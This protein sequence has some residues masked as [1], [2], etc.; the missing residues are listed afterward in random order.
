MT[1]YCPAGSMNCARFFKALD[2]LGISTC[3]INNQVVASFEQCP[4]PS[5][6]VTIDN[7]DYNLAL[8]DALRAIGAMDWHHNNT[9]RKRNVVAAIEGLRRKG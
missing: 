8:D 9:C 7:S 3:S 4:W 6:Q 2:P 5:Y 1:K